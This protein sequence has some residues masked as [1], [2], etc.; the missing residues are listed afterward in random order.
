MTVDAIRATLDRNPF[1]PLRMRTS[2]GVEYRVTLPDQL[3]LFGPDSRKRIVLNG[4][5]KELAVES[6]VSLAP[7]PVPPEYIVG[8]QN[9]SGVEMTIEKFDEFLK[10]QPFVPF[11]IHVGDGSSFEVK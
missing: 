5:G 4:S 3:A 9:K 6:V 2:A 7:E 8:K 11:T 10:R 1:V